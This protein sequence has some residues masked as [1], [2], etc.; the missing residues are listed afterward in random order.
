MCWCWRNVGT[1]GDGGDGGGVSNPG[2]PGEGR[3]GGAGGEKVDTLSLSGSYGSIYQNSGLTL[4]PG[5]EVSTVPDGGR[6]ISCTKGEYWTDQG[7]ASL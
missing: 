7:V 2:T 4:Y 1:S 6:T 5:D 3:Q